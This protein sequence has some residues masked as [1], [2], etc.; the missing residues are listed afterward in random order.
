[1]PECETPVLECQGVSYFPC[2]FLV[3]GGMW[4]KRRFG[5]AGM[6][7]TVQTRSGA[8][9]RAEDEPDCDEEETTD[10]AE[11][12]AVNE[13]LEPVT[14]EDLTDALAGFEPDFTGDFIGDGCM[15]IYQCA[16][17]GAAAAFVRYRWR[18]PPCHPG[19]WYK[20]EWDEAFFPQAF[21]DWLELELDPEI[22]PPP[23][24]PT[25]TP[26]AWTWTGT[27]L[28]PCDVADEDNDYDARY[29]ILLRI[30]PWSLPMIPPA[31]GTM[32]ICNVRVYC[33]QNPFGS[34]PQS[35]D[36]ALGTPTYSGDTASP[37]SF[38]FDDP[39]NSGILPLIF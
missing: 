23:D 1:M 25:L 36:V 4:K 16:A 20:I 10:P 22:T 21:L 29:P 19:S 38:A 9:V 27:A 18:V 37:S 24:L 39:D 7:I 34:K 31:P 15:A 6:P 30:S 12:D 32:E 14:C 8:W 26:K 5:A 3:D 13:L 17:S 28:G 35:M 2:V 33:Y 11:E